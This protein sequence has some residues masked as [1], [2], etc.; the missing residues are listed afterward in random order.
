M[1]LIGIQGHWLGG[2]RV[3]CSKREVTHSFQFVALRQCGRTTL[4]IGSFALVQLEKRNR[5]TDLTLLQRHSVL[6]SDA[7]VANESLPPN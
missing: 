2:T 1:A 6:V 7:F 4:T 5:P 3:A